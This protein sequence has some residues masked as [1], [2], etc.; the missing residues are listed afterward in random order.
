MGTET[1]GILTEVIYPSLMFGGIG[2][3]G[4][5][6]LSIAFGV[7]P[8]ESFKNYIWWWRNLPSFIMRH[9][10]QLCLIENGWCL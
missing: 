3:L 1:D 2:I 8:K 10:S 6:I 7:P 4:I 9:R 5:T